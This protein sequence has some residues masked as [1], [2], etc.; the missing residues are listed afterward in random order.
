MY[1]VLNGGATLPGRVLS[2]TMNASGVWSA[3]QDLTL[4]PV[5]N[6]NM[7]MNVYGFDISSLTIDP[8]DTTGNT[9]VATVAGYLQP[10]EIVRVIYRSTDGGAHWVFITAN[11]PPTPANALVLDPQDSNIAYLATDRGVFSTQ[12]LS[13]CGDAVSNCWSAFGTGLPE[14][15]VVALSAAPVTGSLN[16]LAAA[17][18]GRGVWQT[19]LLTAGIQLTTVTVDPASLTFDIQPQGS[20]SSVQT[21]TLTNTG[22]IALSPTRVEVTGDFIETDNCANAVVHEGAS[23]TIQVIFAPNQMGNRTGQLTVSANVSGGQ[24][25]IPLSGTGVAP[26]L[27]TL[28]PTTINFGRVQAGSTSTA[29]QITAENSGGVAVAITS[30]SVTGPFVVASNACGTTSLAANSSCQMT[31]KFE[32]ATAGP[33]TGTLTMVDGVGTQTVQLSGIGD[34]PATDT[35]SPTSLTFAG[36]IIGAL[37]APQTVAL[38]NTGDVPLT[39]I[40]VSVSGPYQ[41]SSNCTSQLTGQSNC[42]INVVFLPTAAG[43]QAG[44]L[45]VADLLRSQTVPLSGTGLLPPEFSVSPTSLTFAAQTVGVAGVPLVLTVTNSG[46]APMANVGFQMTGQS[47]SSFS[48]G[49]TTCSASLGSGSSCTVQV[50][51]APTA[52]GLVA[53]SLV[54]SSSTL[55]VTPATVPLSGTGKTQAGLSAS[56]AQLTFAAQA[57]GQ[58]SAPQTVTITNTGGTDAGGFAIAVSGPFS[59]THNGCGTSLAAGASCTTGVVFSPTS[60]GALTGA[61]NASSTN[62]TTPATVALSGTGGLT[63]AV[64]LQPALVNFPMT[65]VGT[66]SSAVSVTVTNQSST[67]ALANLVVSASSG[68]KLASN[69]CGASLA[70]G[71]NCAAGIDF[72]PTTAGAQ[73]GTL[74]VRSSVLMAAASAPLS[75]VGFDFTVS[76]GGSASKTVASG[77]AANYTLNL[78]PSAGSAATFTFQCGTLPLYAGCV[79]NPASE[80]IAANATGTETVQVTTSQTKAMV[81]RPSGLGGWRN[82]PFACVMLLIPLAN[83]KRCRMLMLSLLLGFVVCGASS[84]AS[85]GGGSGGNT[86]A[87]TQAANNTPA[88]TYSIPVT[89]TSNGVEHSVTLTLVV[90]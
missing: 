63:G 60:T 51:F 50:T 59:V 41:V 40:A 71:A 53:A 37:S 5:T 16:V 84:C 36:T 44:T 77:Q 6:D 46:G 19:P 55:G 78:A 33:A 24:V 82:L 72:A 81:V 42:S 10:T 66:T 43:V 83:R 54:V 75:G 4:N 17:T 58:S 68:F 73:T 32:P 90:D 45:T 76:A 65:G 49:S 69:T 39:S 86:P 26:A 48:A 80:T 64:L 89:I 13:H 79:F 8:R 74:T 20:G 27:V 70:P 9:I 47:S 23:C 56:P 31:V 57:L 62:M 29:L 38:A 1:G 3:W 25:G 67:V 87:P 35:L 2:A 34:A 22:S 85:S 30:V 12:Q 14:A 18:Y 28:S 52:S 88:G 11:L 7:G 15:P 21:V 61:L